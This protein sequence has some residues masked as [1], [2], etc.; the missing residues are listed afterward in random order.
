MSDFTCTARQQPN[1]DLN[2]GSLT[3]HRATVKGT[4]QRGFLKQTGNEMFRITPRVLRI[5]GSKFMK[6]PQSWSDA[7]EKA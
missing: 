3:L 1:E 5:G 6:L 7:V 4:H 2:S